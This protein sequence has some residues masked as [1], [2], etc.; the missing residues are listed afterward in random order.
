VIP[1]EA[2]MPEAALERRLLE[3]GHEGKNIRL[4]LKYEKHQ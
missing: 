2:N 4:K 1:K 3:M